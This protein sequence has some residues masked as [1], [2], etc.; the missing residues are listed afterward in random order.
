MTDVVKGWI[1]AGGLVV[2]L[3]QAHPLLAGAPAQ[4]IKPAISHATAA[5]AAQ[6]QGMVSK[7]C[8]TCHNDRTKTGEPA[9]SCR[10]GPSGSPSPTA[11]RTSERP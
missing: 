6:V 7:Y 4:A 5:D 9:A 1:G 2:G 3:F 11:R 10:R 8:I